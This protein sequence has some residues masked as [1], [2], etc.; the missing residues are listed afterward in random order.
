MSNNPEENRIDYVEFP[1]PWAAALR[2][3]KRFY[4]E[5]F[6]W[7]FKDRAD[8]YVDSQGSGTASGNTSQTAIPEG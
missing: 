7:S 3:S 5:V 8:N 2:A 1:A 4:N 6:G